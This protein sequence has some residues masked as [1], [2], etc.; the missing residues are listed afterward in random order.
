MALTTAE[1]AKVKKI[2]KKQDDSE[3]VD[4]INRIAYEEIAILRDQIKAIDDKRIQDIKN[5]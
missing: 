1:I 2:I 4:E 5:L 3:T